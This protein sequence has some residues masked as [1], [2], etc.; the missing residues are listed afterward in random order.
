MANLLND[1]DL[2]SKDSLM[3]MTFFIMDGILWGCWWVVIFSNSSCGLSSFGWSSLG[4][5]RRV[6]IILGVTIFRS[7]QT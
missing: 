4:W 1:V 2:R 3:K 5:E 7:S 6:R